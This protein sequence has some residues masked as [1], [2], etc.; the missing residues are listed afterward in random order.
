M[1]SIRTTCFG[2]RLPSSG[3]L[4]DQRSTIPTRQSRYAPSDTT[5]FTLPTL[6]QDEISADHKR[7]DRCLYAFYMQNIR[8]CIQVVP[9]GKDLTSG[10]CSLGQT[11]PI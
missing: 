10:E 2:S 7:P 1:T 6:R 11:I 5:Y 8:V 4:S 3:S 9:G